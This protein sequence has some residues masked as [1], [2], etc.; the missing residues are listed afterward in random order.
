MNRVNVVRFALY[1]T[2]GIGTNLCLYA[3]F[4]IFVAIGAL[5]ILVSALCYILGVTL[6]LFAQQTLDVFD[7]K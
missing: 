3:V 7:P 1:E 2:I 4:L 6:S 5:P